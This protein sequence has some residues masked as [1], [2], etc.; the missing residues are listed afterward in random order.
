METLAFARSDRAPGSHGRAL[1]RRAVHRARISGRPVPAPLMSALD[2][3]ELAQT[4]CA[5]AR[6]AGAAIMRVYAGDFAVE[7]KDDDSPLTA[8][9]LAAHR[10]IVDRLHALTPRIPLLSEESAEQAGW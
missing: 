3:R 5:I 1:D 8:A 9:D 6:D 2:L 10:T 7:H 4:G